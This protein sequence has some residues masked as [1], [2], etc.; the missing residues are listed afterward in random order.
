MISTTIHK[1]NNDIKHPLEATKSWDLYLERR[2]RRQPLQSPG[3][4]RRALKKKR[5]VH[6][7]SEPPKHNKDAEIA[8]T[9]IPQNHKIPK[10]EGSTMHGMM[11]DAG[12]V[13]LIRC[14]QT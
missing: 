7:E 3:K 13:S 4:D 12:S 8:I 5:D 9:H 1:G 11:I 10:A 6:D 14:N 2:G